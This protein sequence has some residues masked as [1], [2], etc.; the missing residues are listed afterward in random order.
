MH[1]ITKVLCEMLYPANTIRPPTLNQLWVNVSCL[2]G[3]YF[4]EVCE[5]MLIGLRIEA[6][7]YRIYFFH[8]LEALSRYR[9]LQLKTV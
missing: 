5:V 4:C 6:I 3:T 1:L 7:C 8:R 2:L 9:D